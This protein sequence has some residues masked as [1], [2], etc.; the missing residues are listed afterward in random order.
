MPTDPKSLTWP[1]LLERSRTYH[2]HPAVKSDKLLTDLTA[3][4]SALNEPHLGKRA[5]SIKLTARQ[6]AEHVIEIEQY[7]KRY[8][9]STVSNTLRLYLIEIIERCSTNSYT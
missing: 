7:K 4:E 5:K 2:N 9:S 6:L 3:I 1:E 8:Y